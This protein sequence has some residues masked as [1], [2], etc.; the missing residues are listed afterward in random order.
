MFYLIQLQIV[1]NSYVSL[2]ESNSKS[3]K[4]PAGNLTWLFK[5]AMEIVDIP[6]KSG[7]FPVRYFDITRGYQRVNP[8]KSH[9]IPLNH[10]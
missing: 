7:D 3:G 2:P 8:I 6:I 10:H 9:K 1:L 5:M 4:L